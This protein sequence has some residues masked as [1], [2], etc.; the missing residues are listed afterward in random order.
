M[1]LPVCMRLPMCI[2]VCVCVCACAC[3][4]CVLTRPSPAPR[5][6]LAPFAPEFAN[7]VEAGCSARAC[8]KGAISGC[9]KAVCSSGV[10]SRAVPTATTR[11]SPAPSVRACLCSSPRCTSSEGCH[12]GK[13]SRC[14]L[15]QYQYTVACAW[16]ASA[17][18]HSRGQ[19]LLTIV[20]V[21]HMHDDALASCGNILIALHTSR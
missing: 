13:M 16:W 1:R 19:A 6:Y 14:E 18:N 21:R 10:S 12:A 2:C 7:R 4:H 5:S 3:V 8:V 15:C 11:W 9:T 20:L 17:I